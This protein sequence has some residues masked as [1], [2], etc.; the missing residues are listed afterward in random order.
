MSIVKI[1]DEIT[2]PNVTTEKVELASTNSVE[3]TWYKF[4][5]GIAVGGDSYINCECKIWIDTRYGHL[6]IEYRC[7]KHR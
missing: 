1:D 6:E 5:A 3:T 4:S 2:G 7:E